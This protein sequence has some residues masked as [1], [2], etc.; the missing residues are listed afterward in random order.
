MPESEY[1]KKLKEAV[2]KQ[3]GLFN[4]HLHLDRASTLDEKFWEH[5]GI[6]PVEASSYSLKAK[7]NL[8]G[9]LHLGPAY[10]KSSLLERMEEQLDLMISVGTK[11]ADSFIDVSPDIGF[12]ALDA[13][14]ELKE[15][16]KNQI[17]FRIGAY[18]IFGFRDDLPQRW[19]IFLEG[20]KR[21]D[22]I[23]TLPERD[24]KKD[25]PNHV[26]FIEHFKRT[27]KL[28]CEL[29]KP[30]HYHVDQTNNPAENGTE[31]LVDA[32]KWLD[33]PKIDKHP[34]VWAVHSI[35][36]SAYD[37]KRFQ[38][39]LDNLSEYNIGVICCPSAAISMRQLRPI[40]APTHNSIARILEML[41]K[42]I[43]VRIGSDNV[44]DIFLPSTTSNLYDEIFMLSN[45]VRFYN[46][47]I[48][49]KLAT[50]KELNDVDREMIERSLAQDKE[51][52]G[53]LK[54]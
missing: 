9:N 4:A 16:K 2:S 51:I 19:E 44:A 14:L 40:N 46:T 10:E 54:I 47:S 11:R 6:N 18:P 22:Y 53:K 28:A 48:M 42:E 12:V 20:A 3:E 27:L 41:A 24:D 23:G 15:K 17:D 45:S 7:Q 13:A 29:K 33:V 38:I 49:T 21:A 50:G 52:F 25:H 30:I 37:E 26:G 5:A 43:P 32:V 34:S 35:S 8:T 36:S 1:Y 31:T 39:L